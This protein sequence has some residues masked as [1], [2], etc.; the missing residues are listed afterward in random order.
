MNAGWQGSTTVLAD[1]EEAPFRPF[2]LRVAVSSTSGVFSDGFGLGIIG[3][4]LSAASSPLQLSPSWLGSIGAASLAGLFAGA[5][6]TGPVADRFGRRPLFAWNM[7]VLAVLSL[8]QWLVGTAWELLLLRLAIG[9]VLGTDYVVSKALLTEFSPRRVRGRVL[10]TLSI[11]WAAGYVCAYVVG[12]SLTDS[13]PAA[14][15]WM[16]VSSAIPPLLILPLRLSIPESPMWLTQQGF[17]ARALKVVQDHIGDDVAAPVRSAASRRGWRWHQL[18]SRPWRRHTAVGCVFFTCQ[19]IP[20]FAVGTFITEVIAHLSTQRGYL[21]GLAYNLALL[22]GSLAGRLIVDWISRRA[23]LLG[24]F[25]IT[26]VTMLTLSAWTGLPD[27]AVVVLLAVF[28]CVLSAQSTLVYVYLPE[29]FPTELRASGI[30][31]A[32]ACSRLGS[33]ASTFL[34]P[35][36]VA[37]FGV[38]TALGA[39]VGT[40]VFGLIVCLL[41]APETKS[42]SLGSLER[43]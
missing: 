6:L 16:L 38:R 42:L 14:W 17:P 7:A 1:Y 39:C 41:W 12:Y 30:G 4:S 36:V 26:G 5:L 11:A 34:L 33:A 28:A 37:T 40:L 8:A 22:G 2:H 43:P 15:R 10:S 35:V 21:G 9:F 19:V 32:V 20:Y 18:L 24:S 25:A 23:F 13:G 31:L 27:A 3:I 29:L